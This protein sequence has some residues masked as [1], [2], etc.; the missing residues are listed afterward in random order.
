MRMK[1][2]EIL[3][4]E[5]DQSLGQGFAFTNQIKG[6]KVSLPF[7]TPGKSARKRRQ[8]EADQTGQKYE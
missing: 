3:F 2:A 4:A 8:G 1:I 5:F 7:V 6:E